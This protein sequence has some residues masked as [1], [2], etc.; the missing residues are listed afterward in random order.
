M[1]NFIGLISVMLGGQMITLVQ[2]H[3]LWDHRKI[4]GFYG[5]GI[6]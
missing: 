5:C 4:S 6:A 3:D 1:K 2:T